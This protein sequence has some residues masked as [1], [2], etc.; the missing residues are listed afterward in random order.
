MRVLVFLHS[1]EA[2]GVERVALRLAGE[3]AIRG[4]DVRVAMGRDNGPQNDVAPGNLTYDFARRSWLAAPFETLWMVVHL[5]GAIRRH[6]PDVLFC[7]GSTY[8]IVVALVRLVLGPN[9]PPVACKL[10]NS[11]ERRDLAAPAR[12]AF[13]LWLRA[14]RLFIDRF[15]GM[16]EPMRDEI[17]RLL[18]VA[19]ARIDIIPDPALKEVELGDIANGPRAPSAARCFVAI[20]R[21]NAQKNFPLLLKAF[22]DA[23]SA[24]DRL[25]II[26][27]GP[28][29]RRLLRLAKRLGIADQVE[30]PG[31]AQSSAQALSNA[32]VFVLSSNYEGVPAVIIE[33]LAAGVPIVATD[34]SVSMN[35]L[36][37]GGQLGRLVAVR[38]RAALARAMHAA[39]SRDSVSVAEMQAIASCFTIERAAGPY[40]AVLASAVRDAEA[41]MRLGAKTAEIV[42]STWSRRDMETVDL[43][44]VG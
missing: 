21:M 30:M 22:S 40:L 31:H 37:G 32:D 27:D 10:S 23:A 29:R 5:L 13:H 15:V 11:L 28:Q 24:D 35:L 17:E 4:H 25:V 20:G 26:G 18:A 43:D 39:P 3:W 16:A 44:T 14:H 9:C 33:A 6:R 34:C 7:A 12:T 38:D 2:G 41:R 8:V 42:K 36:L 19:A 1:F